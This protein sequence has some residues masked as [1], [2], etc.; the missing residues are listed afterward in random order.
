MARC[1]APL[2]LPFYFLQVLYL[3]PSVSAR[4]I[5]LPRDRTH[6]PLIDRE[7]AR[8]A[9]RP[10]GAAVGPNATPTDQPEVA[11]A[12]PDSFFMDRPG[13]ATVQPDARAVDRP[14]RAAAGPDAR[15][16]DRPGGAARDMTVCILD[17]GGIALDEEVPW[18]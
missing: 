17:K 15:G 5:G 7:E 2:T 4:T 1:V 11:A 13:R 6:E 14:G 3:L 8:A 12:G 10:G 18:A 9:D 16:A